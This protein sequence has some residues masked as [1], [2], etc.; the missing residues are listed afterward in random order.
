MR[1]WQVLLLALVASLIL[2]GALGALGFGVVWLAVH[3]NLG[4]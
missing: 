1:V 2:F 3:A 4:G